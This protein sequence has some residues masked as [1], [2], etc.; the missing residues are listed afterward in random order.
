MCRACAYGG[1]FMPEPEG[2]IDA[3]EAGGWI[4]MSARIPVSRLAAMK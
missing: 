1:L 3:Y 2:A 4:V